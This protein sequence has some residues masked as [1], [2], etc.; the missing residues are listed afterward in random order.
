[1]ETSFSEGGTSSL[2][3]LAVPSVN[4]HP[5]RIA[6]WNTN[7]APSMLGRLYRSEGIHRAL[8]SFAAS[9]VDVISIQETNAFRVGPC[10]YLSYRIMLVAFGIAHALTTLLIAMYQRMNIPFPFIVTILQRGVLPFTKPWS[11]LVRVYD[12][13]MM[14]EAMVLPLFVIDT[15]SELITWAAKHTPYRYGMRSPLPWYGMNGG[16]LVLSRHPLIQGNG[17]ENV[18]SPA[19]VIE[20]LPADVGNTPSFLSVSVQL[21]P[22]L[23]VR[24]INLHM[25][26][27]LQNT[28]VAYR[29]VNFLNRLFRWDVTELNHQAARRVAREIQRFTSK[30][31]PSSSNNGGPYKNGIVVPSSN[32][33]NGH[34]SNGSSGSLSTWSVGGITSAGGR[35]VGRVVIAGDLNVEHYS[36]ELHSVS[37][38]LA[39]TPLPLAA[40]DGPFTTVDQRR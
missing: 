39:M 14:V 10:T 26:A 40:T 7:Q 1:M 12:Y 4:G 38:T 22:T 15:T 21:T 25:I 17:D 6:T 3:P 5:F 8:H 13:A 37:Q 34:I 24:V 20:L 2:A 27:T 11:Q 32:G 35:G 23:S 30:S 28:T 29:V 16:L 31:T 18:V 9:N 33:T 19:P 36:D